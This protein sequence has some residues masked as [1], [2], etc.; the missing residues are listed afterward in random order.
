[1]IQL[2]EFL[3]RQSDDFF[4]RLRKFKGISLAAVMSTAVRW[5]NR[6]RVMTEIV[7]S[8]CSAIGSDR[9]GVRIS[10][11]NKAWGIS[12]SDP[13]AT[14]GR[15]AERLNDFNLAYLHVLEARLNSG[16]FM[17]GV[18]YITPELR[19]IYKSNFLANGGYTK[20]SGQ[21][22]LTSGEADAIVYGISFIASLDLAERFRED[23]LLAEEIDSGFCYHGGNK[24]YT[25]YPPLTE[26][27][28]E[29]GCLE[30]S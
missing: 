25:D 4:E 30:S 10:P 2:P 3:G 6:L 19:A 22:T 7:G 14:F 24:G 1:M 26:G 28:R 17:E 13:L 21:R 5:D 23:A 27:C 9:V 8:V 11:T 15:V 29:K 18:D 20:K 12:D 16:H